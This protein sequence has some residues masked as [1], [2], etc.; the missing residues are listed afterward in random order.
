[1]SQA[2]R[3]N[4]GGRAWKI[5]LGVVVGLL[6]FL[7]ALYAWDYFS[8]KDDVPRGTS[9]GGVEIGGMPHDEAEATLRN[10]LGGVETEPVTVT[11]G[12]QGG[13]LIP[14]ESGLAIDWAATVAQ[15][16]TESA[17]PIERI[18]GLFST[19]EVSVVSEVDE[20]ALAPQVDRVSEELS[21][22]P[23]DGG[24]AIEGADVVRI[25]PVLGQTVDRDTL[26]AEVA[27]DWLNPEGINAPPVVVEP[28]I[29]DE[30]I[31]EAADGPAAA[32]VSG[33]LVVN[34]QN[35]I[36]GTIGEDRIGE[37]VTFE[38]VEGSIEPRVN[39]EVATSILSEQL[40]D[41]ET[42]P[43]NAR[44]A[45]DGSVTPH[46]DGT[47][48][49]WEATMAGFSDRV[50]STDDR[51]WDAEYEPTPAEYT[52][53]DAENA[54]FNQVVGEFTTTG[55]SA[56]SGTNI[57]VMAN[58]VNGAIVGPGE[59]F[60]LNQHT[61]PRGLAQGYVE[62][63]II[64]NGRSSTGVG[65]GASQYTT[66]L[67]NAAYFAGMEDVA[68]TPHSYYISRYPAGREA[69]I[70]EGSIDL[71][72][73]NTSDNPVRIE[74]SVGDDSVTVRLMGVKT[75]NVESIDG[76]RWAETEPQ[77]QE[78][79]GENCIPSSGIPGFTTS[80]TRVITD[81]SGNELTRESQ[82]TVYDPQPIVR[83]TG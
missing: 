44:I 11:A 71:V 28:A 59:T 25:D 77:V 56:A 37:I 33:P 76:G 53:E 40:I 72:F 17:N 16:G 74:S 51:E 52:T 75:V 79:S 43:V 41:S 49:D 36:N 27:E 69:T 12:E 4:K 63:G 31:D 47:L 81:L 29:N 82:T 35:D 38:N 80:D 83:C 50:L 61:G 66:T 14:A 70:W 22:D 55:F 21:T 3:I 32:A 13:E 65:G 60:S 8:N 67:Y 15:T 10:E 73:R 57:G 23:T 18:Q 24:L 68:H 5:T 20:A 39:T 7:G 6:V 26:S 34:G 1:M 48:I 2:S 58:E 62:S 30:V 78:V 54:S 45:T 46:V 42:E 19:T 64:E 9:V